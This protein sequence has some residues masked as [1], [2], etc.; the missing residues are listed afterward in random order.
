MNPEH[1]HPLI[2]HF[3]IAPLSIAVVADLI[4]FFSKNEFFEK[5]SWYNYILAGFFSVLTIISGLIAEENVLINDN[6]AD[7]FEYHENFAFILI[8]L[9][10]ILVFWRFGLKGKN[11]KKYNYIYY[12]IS[13]LC[14]LTV[15]ITAYHGGRLVFEH[16]ISVKSNITSKTDSN[17]PIDKKVPKYN[18]TIPDTTTN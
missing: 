7:V 2:V 14:F 11:P 12:F 9:L 5:Y 8:V 10:L 18:F 6:A 3:L 4:W 1:F 13:I 16:G 15:F 17:K